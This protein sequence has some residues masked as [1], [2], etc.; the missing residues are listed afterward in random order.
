MLPALTYRLVD[1]LP[2]APV[3]A[4]APSPLRGSRPGLSVDCRAA[5]RPTPII[6]RKHLSSD[7]PM[8]LGALA[9]RRGRGAVLP[10][11]SACIMRTSGVRDLRP[12]AST[13]SPL[14]AILAAAASPS[15]ARRCSARHRPRCAACGH[16]AIRSGRRMAWIRAL[17]ECPSSC[18]PQHQ[19]SSGKPAQVDHNHQPIPERQLPRGDLPHGCL[20]PREGNKLCIGASDDVFLFLSMVCLE[21]SFAPRGARASFDAPKKRKGKDGKS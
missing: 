19:T 10:A 9:S 7:D 14:S 21:R 16:L 2:V 11:C 15:V 3:F 6:G 1:L 5:F 8:F 20:L 4:T 12:R 13:F 17:N 18:W